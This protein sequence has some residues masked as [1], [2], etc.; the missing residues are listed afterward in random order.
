MHLRTY[1][2]QSNPKYCFS[3]EISKFKVGIDLF[4][5]P[6][7]KDTKSSKK[8]IDQRKATILHN[9]EKKLKKRKRLKT[10]KDTH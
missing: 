5:Y 3:S 1:F 6:T 9:I 8:N 2:L 10:F 4:D 7:P